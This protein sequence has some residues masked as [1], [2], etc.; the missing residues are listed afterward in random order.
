MARCRTQPAA[1]AEHNLTLRHIACV[2]CGQRLSV[3]HRAQRTVR[4]LGGVWRLTLTLRRA[5][6]CAAL[7]HPH[8]LSARSRATLSPPQRQASAM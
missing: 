1:T 3:A 2:A 8:L 5:R 7:A 4:R 6:A